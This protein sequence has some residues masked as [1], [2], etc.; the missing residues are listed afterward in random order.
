M[1]II[2]LD[3]PVNED[4]SL[5]IKHRYEVLRDIVQGFKIGLPAIV[6]H[7]TNGIVSYFKGYDGLLIAD[8][9]L[10]DIGDI[11]ALV[12]KWLKKAGFNTVIAHGFVGYKQGLEV[13]ARTC[14]EEEINLVMVVSMSHEGSKEFIDKHVDDFL[15]LAKT[16]ETWGV[17]APA[18]RPEVIKYIRS[19]L[20]TNVK[21]LSPGVGAQGA[22][23]G[24][25]L[26]AGAD[27]EIIGRA[28]TH[29][30]DIRGTALNIISRQRRKVIECRG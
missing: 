29:A 23:P 22:S 12:T 4:A 18:T 7:G 16:I 9:K 5:W 1:I 6:K 30:V 3:P 19:K 24:D 15:E 20:G 10:A 14:K 26:C 2:A 17:V 27:Y 8:L 21:I 28:I 25:A 11:M 13:L